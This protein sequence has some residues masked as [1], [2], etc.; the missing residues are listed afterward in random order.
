MA[1]NRG[2]HRPIVPR[3]TPQELIAAFAISCLTGGLLTDI[4][5]WK[6]AEF[7]WADFSAWLISAGVVAAV[8]AIVV[9]LVDYLVFRSR[10]RLVPPLPYLLASLLVLVLA[11]FNMMIHSRD[12]WTSVVPWGLTLSAATVVVLLAAALWRTMELRRACREVE[13]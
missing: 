11:I 5:Y 6:S 3:Y 1:A 12:A 7:I 9:A 2:I 8:L 4:A 10:R 13:P